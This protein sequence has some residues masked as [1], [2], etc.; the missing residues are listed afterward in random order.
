MLSPCM[1]RPPPAPLARS[2]RPLWEE[3]LLL[4][5][6]THSPKSS[7]IPPPS[8][9]PSWESLRAPRQVRASSMESAK[10][11]TWRESQTFVDLS[12]KCDFQKLLPL[13]FFFFKILEQMTSKAALVPVWRRNPLSGCSLLGDLCRGNEEAL[14]PR[15]G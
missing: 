13:F 9:L 3:G 12:S 11:L 15:C 14:W 7:L 5:L 2:P 1:L 6:H 8:L 4:L 10:D